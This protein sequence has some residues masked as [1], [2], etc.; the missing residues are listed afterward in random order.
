M[1]KSTPAEALLPAS[2]VCARYTR[3]AKTL[4]RW[5]KDDT[6]GFP[7][8]V[9]IRNRRYFREAELIDWERAQAGKKAA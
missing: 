1:D 6:L 9:V 7:R 4:D 3:S 2:K 8:P 5:L